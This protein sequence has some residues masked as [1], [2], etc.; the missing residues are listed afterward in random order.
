MKYKLFVGKTI[1]KVNFLSGEGFSIDFGKNEHFE[2]YTKVSV[3]S[4][5]YDLKKLVGKKIIDVN[6]EKDV[7]ITFYFNE[8]SLSFSLEPDLWVTPEDV[9]YKDYRDPNKLIIEIID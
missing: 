6:Y 1:Q 5:K 9:V 3:S 8:V 7:E 2:C 4:K